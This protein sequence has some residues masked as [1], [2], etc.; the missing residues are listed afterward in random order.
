M[1]GDVNMESE[2]SDLRIFDLKEGEVLKL[3]LPLFGAC[4]VGDYW[5]VMVHE[6]IINDLG[7]DPTSGDQSLYVKKTKNGGS[8]VV[9]GEPENKLTVVL[10]QVTKIPRCLLSKN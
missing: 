1:T 4:I 8:L 10:K 2:P 3:E 7:M 5:R 6:H 9:E